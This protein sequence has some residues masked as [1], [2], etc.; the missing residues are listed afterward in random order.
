MEPFELRDLAAAHYTKRRDEKGNESLV[1]S[2][3]TITLSAY[4]ARQLDE[5]T[6]KLKER[7]HLKAAEVP[8][9]TKI[10]KAG[11]VKLSSDDL[12][13]VM[14]LCAQHGVMLDPPQA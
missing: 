13:K 10:S 11:A 3:T 2:K 12:V 8:K 1:I 9:V 14:S 7:N 5:L 6:T 4:L